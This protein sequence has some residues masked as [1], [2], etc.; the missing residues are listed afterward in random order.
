[1]VLIGPN[2]LVQ[3]CIWP[4]SGRLWDLVNRV[5]HSISELIDTKQICA[6]GTDRY[7]LNTAAFIQIEK[8]T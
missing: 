2:L 7:L 6:T 4:I 8:F 3:G 1:M 5:G